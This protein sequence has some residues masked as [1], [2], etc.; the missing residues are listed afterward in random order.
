MQMFEGKNITNKR[1]NKSESPEVG[2]D[3]VSLQ[4]IEINVASV[5]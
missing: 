4:K 1:N 3:L 2:A 5:Q